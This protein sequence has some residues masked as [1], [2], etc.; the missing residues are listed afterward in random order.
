MNEKIF[1]NISKEIIGIRRYL[2]KYPEISLKEYNTSKYIKD[3][4]DNINIDSKIIGETG[5]VAN[6]FIGK[7]YPTVAIRAEIDAIPVLEENDLEY[8]SVNTGVM[9]GCGHDAIVATALGLAKLLNINKKKLNCNVKFIFQPGEETGGGSLK[10][11]N[12]GV[13]QNSEVDKIIFF[14]YTNEDILGMDMQKNIVSATVGSMNINIKGKSC[15]W[16]EYDKGIDAI[17][18]AG[19]VIQSIKNINETY[20]LPNPFILGIGKI[21]GGRGKS[22]IADNVDIEGTI[23]TYSLEEYYRLV[24]VIKDKMKLIENKDKVKIDIRVSE[25]PVPPMYN[26]PFLIEK[27]VKVGR[28][29]F[30]E[31]CTVSDTTYL[32]GDNASF[33]LKDIEGIFIAFFD[34]EKNEKAYPLH[35][36]K[37]N[38]SEKV[39]PYALKTLYNL[40]FEIYR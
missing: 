17:S 14:H 15:H 27:A 11:I 5:V 4:L 29:I 38:I 7:D 20:D 30:K 35:H 36:P 12:E 8:V 1:N 34:K 32:S 31:R 10:L 22:V 6:I 21:N 18:S 3:Y 16:C 23:R 39:M 9:H 28:E 2:H 33:Y 19:K 25:N 40:V 26:S 24:D 13:L 37:F